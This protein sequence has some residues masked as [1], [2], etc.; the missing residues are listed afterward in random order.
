MPTKHRDVL[1]ASDAGQLIVTLHEQSQCLRIYPFAY[2]LE[3]EKDIQDLPTIND[4]IATAI[5]RR[6]LGNASEVEIDGSGRVLIPA[7]LR[8]Y[9]R[10]EKNLVLVGQ[11]ARFELWNE[12][13]WD[14]QMEIPTDMGNSIPSEMVKMLKL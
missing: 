7:K 11:G 5:K 14:K 8:E 6:V 9:A 1:L 10:L 13:L 2:W 3:I 12:E 4:P